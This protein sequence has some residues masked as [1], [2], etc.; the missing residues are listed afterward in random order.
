MGTVELRCKTPSG[1]RTNL[2]REV[3]Y[4]PWCSGVRLFSVRKATMV[5]AEVVFKGEVCQV[6]IRQPRLC[7]GR[8]GDFRW[9]LLRCLPTLGQFG[10]FGDVLA[11]AQGSREP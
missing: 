11:C 8:T 3:A 7:F 4:V 5:G 6:F 10:E 9:H 1:E 2:L